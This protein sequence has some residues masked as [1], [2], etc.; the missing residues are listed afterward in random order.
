MS[1]LIIYCLGISLCVTL[2]AYYESS[3]APWS[4][5]LILSALLCL[6]LPWPYAL[7]WLSPGF[8]LHYWLHSF[9]LQLFALTLVFQ[10]LWDQIFWA[11]F[12]E[13][14]LK[15]YFSRRL[16]YYSILQAT[17]NLMETGRTKHGLS[18]QKIQLIFGMF[19]LV[20][21]PIAENCFYWGF[22]Y[23]GLR[24]QWD[25]LTS[26]LVVSLLFALRHVFQFGILKPIPWPASIALGINTL[27]SGILMSYLFEKTAS[28]WPL[29]LIHLLLNAIW[30]LSQLF[31][32]KQTE[33]IA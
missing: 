25:F 31:V 8:S 28:L 16:P 11:F 33:T 9:P 18:K 4:P 29:I 17:E 12:Y 26:S 14:I 22:L 32:A 3:K 1:L 2:I 19:I 5:F 13:K 15:K 30:M 7:T 27:G 20:W 21:A 6:F 23:S 24:S 10:L